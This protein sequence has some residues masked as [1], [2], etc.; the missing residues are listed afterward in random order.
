MVPLK[1]QT[2]L[3]VWTGMFGWNVSG[4]GVA[5]L[6]PELKFDATWGL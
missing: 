2:E 3:T 4:M 6:M 5:G 1:V